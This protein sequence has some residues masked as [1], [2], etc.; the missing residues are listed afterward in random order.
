[1]LRGPVP[2]EL[3]V[4]EL[5]VARCGWIG[6]L[7]TIVLPDVMRAGDVFLPPHVQFTLNFN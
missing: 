2:D 3:L 4:V 6:T 5:V 1:M 7:D